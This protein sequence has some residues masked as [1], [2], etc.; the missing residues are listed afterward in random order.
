MKEKIIVLNNI[1][2]DYH[3]E[4]DLFKSLVQTVKFDH[5]Q[6]ERELKQLME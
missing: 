2:D 6:K 5:R 3:L 1:R 4:D